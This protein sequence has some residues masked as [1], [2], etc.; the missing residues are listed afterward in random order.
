M[1]SVRRGERNRHEEHGAPS[2][3]RDLSHA[4]APGKQTRAELTGYH[5]PAVSTSPSHARSS[6]AGGPETLR[7]AWDAYDLLAAAGLHDSLR[8]DAPMA[9]APGPLPSPADPAIAQAT[10][11][12]H[13]NLA[14]LQ[15]MQTS[16]LTAYHTAVAA[17]DAAGARAIAAQLVAGLL[18]VEQAREQVSRWAPHASGELARLRAQLAHE[19]R[20]AVAS[21]AVQL[22]PQ[23]LAWAPVAG[24][25]EPPSRGKVVHLGAELVA[26]EAAMVVVLLEASDRIAALATPQGEASSLPASQ[27]DLRLAVDEFE[28]FQSRPIHA[29]FLAEVLRRRGV[30]PELAQARSNGTART[31]AGLLRGSQAQAAETGMTADVGP[32]WNP[33]KAEDALTYSPSDWAV[34]DDD[35]MQVMEMLRS[36]SPQARG[37]LVRQ[38]HKRGLLARVTENVGW[39][40]VKAIAETLNDPEA[41]ALLAPYWEGKG[42]VPSLGQLLTKQVQDNRQQGGMVNDVQA[43]AWETLNSSLDVFTFGAKPALDAAHEALDA[44]W[45]SADA[46][47]FEASKAEARAIV[48]AAAMAA[49]GGLAGAW[50][51][52]AALTLGAGEGGSAILSSAM[53]GAVGNAGGQLAG[54]T[55][56]QAFS[57]KQGFDSVGSYAQTFAQGGLLGA[58]MAPA[59]LAAARYLPATTRTIAQDI[60]ARHPEMVSVLEAA[61][62]AGA[63][64][65]FRARLTVREW[66]DITRGGGGGPGG[67][68][69]GGLQPVFATAAGISPDLSALPPDAE[70]WITARPKVELNALASRLGDSSGPYFELDAIDAEPRAGREAR[71]RSGSLFD[72]H[73]ANA[74]YADDPFELREELDLEPRFPQADAELSHVLAE[75]GTSTLSGSRLGIGRLPRHHLLPQ[76][77]TRLSYFQE[78]GFP[79]RDIDNFCIEIPTLDHEI[80]HGGNQKL[81][82]SHWQQQEWNTRL[83]DTLDREEQALKIATGD[84]EAKLS[85]E[86]ILYIMEKQRK[87]FGLDI[88]P[89]VKYR[90]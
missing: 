39:Q 74:N 18:Q 27:D 31:A 50:T 44:G 55:F 48:T 61:K 64:A 2:G 8:A 65:A 23:M 66:L 34:T 46:Y 86:R 76:A 90:D 7:E 45:I 28:R 4:P 12:I 67:M 77:K 47:S 38:L 22:S 84:G 80:A 30:W 81:A 85:R 13:Q 10:A 26:Q 25:I 89:L 24:T 5:A 79:G 57:G 43:F 73:G 82:R 21:L 40:Y 1:S 37:G 9:P 68:F 83:F 6:G 16:L 60:A 36:A 87:D 88:Y 62:A 49:T 42:G 15:V 11:L 75:N 69:T 53:G 19:T 54:D 59:G 20:D 33:A 72:D 51:E 56:D 35:A 78:R 52:G 63:G 71:P 29:A 14:H 17:F 58:T 41:E 3:A 70:L 32:G